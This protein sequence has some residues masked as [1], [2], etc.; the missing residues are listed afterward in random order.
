MAPG[1]RNTPQTPQYPGWFNIN[2]TWDLAASLTHVRAES[3]LQDRLCDQP[4]LQS[5]E[6]DAGRGARWAPSTSPRTTHN[7]IDTQLRL[8]QH[9]HRD[10]RLTTRPRSSSSR[11]WCRPTRFE[12]IHPGQL[13]GLA[14]GSRWTTACGSSTSSRRTTRYGQASNF[15]PE[16]W[17]ASAAPKLYVPGCRAAS[18]RARHNAS[19]DEPGDG[20]VA[21]PRNGRADRPGGAR[22]GKFDERHRA[23]GSGN[24]RN[25]LRV[26]EP[27][28]RP[29]G[30]VRVSP[31]GGREVGSPRR[32][33]GSSTTGWR[34]T[35]P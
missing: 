17:T 9:R 14:I 1:L 7:P 32:H 33:S 5:A 2:Q 16:K 34:A 26:S 19:G 12:P 20:P 10:L 23:A 31:E 3:H 4:Q 8:R 11:A 27:E 18:I 21:G 30:G 13:E 25:Q 6:H 29:S 24:R 35:S 28:A 15:F 22:N